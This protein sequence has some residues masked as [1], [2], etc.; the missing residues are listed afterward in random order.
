MSKTQTNSR[1]AIPRTC[2]QALIH[3]GAA[4]AFYLFIRQRRVKIFMR[5]PDG[6]NGATRQAVHGT[7]WRPL[8]R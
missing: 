7:E 8:D 3:T 6:R 1:S 4:C 2:K 5:L